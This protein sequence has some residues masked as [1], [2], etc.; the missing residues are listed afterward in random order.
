LQEENIQP[1]D[2]IDKFVE[3]LENGTSASGTRIKTAN[4]RKKERTT[5]ACIACGKASLE[6]SLSQQE[7][8]FRPSACIT[9]NSK[10]ASQYEAKDKSIVSI[11]TKD[12]F[13]EF[14][15]D[16]E[17]SND[18]NS[19]ITP[20]ATNV[21]AGWDQARRQVELQ[22]SSSF[23]NTSQREAIWIYPS[24]TTLSGEPGFIP[25]EPINDAKGANNNERKE[26]YVFGDGSMGIGN[27]HIHTKDAYEIICKRLES[28][29]ASIRKLLCILL[30]PPFFIMLPWGCC[31]VPK[32]R[33]LK[34]M[35]VGIKKQMEA[36]SPI[37]HHAALESATFLRYAN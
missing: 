26:N 16:I 33:K 34:E 14:V 2:S 32:Q 3:E 28:Q 17:N 10:K 37:G 9:T 20:I 15:T 8:K 22:Q 31:L 7:A 13:E 19:T 29:V 27:Y 5:A 6:K 12:E 25:L 11:S 23:P 36:P 18:A 24:D 35:I 30:I 4:S 21:N 1:V